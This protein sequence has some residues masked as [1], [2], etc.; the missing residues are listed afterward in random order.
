MVKDVFPLP[1]IGTIIEGMHGMVLF[2]KFNLCNGYWNIYN[3]KET[4][5]LMAFKMTRGLYAPRV[6]SFGL[7]NALACMQ[8]FMNYI[9]QPL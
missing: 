7:T 5:D 6:M 9:F 1:H 2:S 3:S 8:W 4:K